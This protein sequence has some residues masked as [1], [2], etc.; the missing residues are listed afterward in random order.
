MTRP[1][2]DKSPRPEAPSVVYSEA[3]KCSFA[4]RFCPPG[5]PRKVDS[6]ARLVARLAPRHPCRRC[7]GSPRAGSPAA[8][9]ADRSAS[10]G[11]PGRVRP[12]DATHI[13]KDEH[14]RT[15]QP[16]AP[17]PAKAVVA[18]EPGAS[19]APNPLLPADPA[20]APS[21]LDS[22]RT[23]WGWCL[24]PRHRPDAAERLNAQ[25]FGSGRSRPLL[26]PHH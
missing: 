6:F 5:C 16:A 19:M 15:Q 17:I 11:D 1:V 24:A 23:A 18:A 26:P 10:R 7:L 25:G 8:I 20:A 13:V 2:K 3:A 4:A 22:A 14:P 21:V 12:T 9:L